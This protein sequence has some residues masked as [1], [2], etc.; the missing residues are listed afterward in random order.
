MYGTR[1][2]II[3]L[4]FRLGG[5][6]DDIFLDLMILFNEVDTIFKIR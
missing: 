3:D 1:E 2:V 5:I 4:F 6:K